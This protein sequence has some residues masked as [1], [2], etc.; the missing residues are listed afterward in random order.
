VTAQ[1]T[2]QGRINAEG[3][4][5]AWR[6]AVSLDSLPSASDNIFLVKYPLNSR[7]L[8]FPL[9]DFQNFIKGKSKSG[10]LSIRKAGRLTIF[11]RALYVS[12]AFAAG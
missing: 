4:V 1:T 8:F 10:Q 9:I 5:A 3:P 7:P 6:D 12:F 2:P 11:W